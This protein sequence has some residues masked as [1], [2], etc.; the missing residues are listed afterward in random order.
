MNRQGESQGNSKQHA[1]D[2]HAGDYIQAVSRGVIHNMV[3]SRPYQKIANA[4]VANIGFMPSSSYRTV[5][6]II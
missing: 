3:C 5:C 1:W 4:P 2:G 6:V